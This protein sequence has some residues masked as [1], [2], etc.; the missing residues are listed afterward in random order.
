MNTKMTVF[1]VRKQTDAN[2]AADAY[3]LCLSR[4]DI[5]KTSWVHPALD[6]SIRQLISK[7]MVT[8]AAKQVEIFPTHGLISYK[9]IIL[10]GVGGMGED[11]QTLRESAVL[12][13]KLARKSKLESLDIRLPFNE[14]ET[15]A[16]DAVYALTEGILLGQYSAKSYRRDEEKITSLGQVT[17]A[18]DAEMITDG[19]IATI[20][21]SIR[22]AEIHADATNYARDLTNL[23]GNYLIPSTLAEEAVALA[24]TYGFECKVLG[25]QEMKTMGMGGVLEVGKGS[26]HPPCMIVIKYQGLGEWTDVLGLVGKGITFDTGGISL[27]KPDGMEEMISDMGGAATI[28]GVMRAVGRL[29]PKANLLAVIP[30]AENMPSGAAFKPGDIVVTLSGKTVEVLNTDAEGRIVLADGMTYAKRLGATKLI[31]VATLTGAVLISLG[32]VAT[33][34][35]TN[36]E[37]FLQELLAASKRAGEKVWQL[38]AYTEY[39]D[40]LKSN[41]ADM[42]N[43]AGNG[44]WAG[45]ITAGL[46]VGTFAEETPW[47]HLDTG[48]TAW[49]WNERG[50]DPKGGTGVMVRTILAMIP[51]KE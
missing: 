44:R 30:A 7:G 20:Q 18:A 36:D 41:V 22:L 26:V 14:K 51:S 13:A 16:A 29:R 12:L 33:A 19:E 34:A 38:P 48:G 35:V 37:S 9:H 1:G 32:D 23:P 39:R 17:Y 15:G 11:V 10:M 4:R 31:D 5:N 42:K 43:S 6:E 8:G 45:A 40:M 2:I 47:I 28:L 21:Q 3:V 49:L 27:K 25:E 46:F 24:E 50:V